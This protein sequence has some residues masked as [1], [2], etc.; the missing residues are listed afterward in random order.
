M[1]R[2]SNMLVIGRLGNLLEWMVNHVRVVMVLAGL[3]ATTLTARLTEE[4][5]DELI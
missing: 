1:S 5:F 3:V 4:P 2:C